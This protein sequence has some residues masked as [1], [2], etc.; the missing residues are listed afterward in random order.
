MITKAIQRWKLRQ[1]TERGN[2]DFHFGKPT[3]GTTPARSLPLLSPLPDWANQMNMKQEEAMPLIKERT[4]KIV[5][6]MLP[7]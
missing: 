5:T 7:Q 4:Q 1:N 6:Q 3:L 2:S